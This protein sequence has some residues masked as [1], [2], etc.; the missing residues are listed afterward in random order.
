M[1]I[2]IKR[3]AIRFTPDPKRVIT[4][5]FMP[6]NQERTQALIY[7]V[8]HMSTEDREKVFDQILR[9]FSN[10]HRN[11]TRIFE[12]NFENVKEIVRGLGIDPDT[13]D[14]KKKL[15]IGAYFTMEFSIEATAF[16]NPSI[17]EDPYQGDLL[18]G[19]KRIIVSF[20]A[21]GE[22][23]ISSL[24]FRSG[25]IDE[26]NNLT[27]KPASGLVDVPEII[28]RY[29]YEKRAFFNKLKEMNIKKDVID[30]VMNQLGDQF[31]YGELQAAIENVMQKK[32][33]SITRK[34]VVNAIKWLASSHYEVMFSLDTAISERV[35]F[36]ISY[37]ESN[38]IEDA[39]FV[40]FS[41][42]DGSIIYYAT[43]T[44]YDGYS[45]L[46]KLIET[47]D[48]YHFKVVPIHGKYSQHKGMA[49]FPR[50]IKGDY[51]MLSR[52]DGMNNYVMFSDNINLWLKAK[53]ILEPVYPWELVQI[54]NA[55]SPIET[56]HGWLVITH[57]VG[58]MRT[59]CLGASLLD[60]E[61]PTKIIGRLKEPLLVANE[62]EREGYVPNVVYSCGSILHNGELIIPYGMSDY[63]T[64]FA[65][66][67]LDELVHQF[68]PSSSKDRGAVRQDTLSI[69]L[70]EDDAKDQKLI[71]KILVE[72]GYTIKVAS[73]GIDA[74]MQIAQ[75]KFDLVLSDIHMPNLDGFQLLE[76]M[77]QK[78][79]HIPV[80]FITGNHD[81]NYDIKS[82]ELGAVAYIEK[83]IQR[84]RL[85]QIL[86]K[87]LNSN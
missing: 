38:G 82:Q 24:V 50:K 79:I 61:N 8:L 48:F 1:A 22:G 75:G 66:V 4:R 23:H 34:K 83:P 6:G 58:P 73:D 37:S 46:P 87:I 33:L 67:S 16:F 18:P 70:V 9:N 43:Y 41:D 49:L 11:I 36:P 72:G 17:V 10:R 55:G 3:K 5:F 84:K 30:L 56:E 69:L 31:K 63:A 35:L 47:K 14:I 85:L 19:Q 59:Y 20:R 7:K 12:K 26:N 71:S 53:K 60:L 13:L 29:I 64:S 76:Q 25:I 45:I 32:D 77:N 80:I 52:I 39:R 81:E 54:G 2:N 74:L 78:Q 21:T 44:A 68:L 42:E 62:E 28:T 40:R 15:T 57:G 86:G 51:A 27:F 65:S